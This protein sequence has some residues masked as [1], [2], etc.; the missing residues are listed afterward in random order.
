MDL[1][2]VATPTYTLIPDVRYL[3]LVFQNKERYWLWLKL[4]SLNWFERYSLKLV[5][6]QSSI[7]LG[8]QAIWHSYTGLVWYTRWSKT[9]LGKLNTI[10]Y[11]NIILFQFEMVQFLNIQDHSII[12]E[13]SVMI[14]LRYYVCVRNGGHFRSK[15]KQN[16]RHF[17]YYHSES[18][19]NVFGFQAPTVFRSPMFQ[20]SLDLESVLICCCRYS[21]WFFWLV[22]ALQLHHDQLL[23]QRQ[24]WHWRPDRCRRPG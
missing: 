1:T 10:P 22:R 9:E 7:K 21:R 5:F 23:C 18:E 2:T 17:E 19:L 3:D 24:R 11:P 14:I 8:I 4:S 16:S 15:S 6:V 20:G 12:L 13:L